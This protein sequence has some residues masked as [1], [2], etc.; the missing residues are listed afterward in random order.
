MYNQSCQD[1]KM[2]ILD[3]GAVVASGDGQR[4][5]HR[6]ERPRRVQGQGHSE[7]HRHEHWLEDP[8]AMSLEPRKRVLLVLGVPTEK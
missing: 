7:E 5:G 3:N 4:Y 1:G 2:E 6:S 8:P